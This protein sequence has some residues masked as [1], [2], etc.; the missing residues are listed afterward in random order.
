MG[1]AVKKTPLPAE[2]ISASS[3]SAAIEITDYSFCYAGASTPVLRDCTFRLNY[4]EL[5][6]LSG[7]SGAGKSTLLASIIGS[8]P[9]LMRGECAGRILING[10]NMEKDASDGVANAAALDGG[11]AGQR[12]AHD[13]ADSWRICERAHLVG[14]VLQDADSQI[15][16]AKVED[17]VAFGCEN[18]GMD[19]AQ[20]GQNVDSSCRLMGLERAWG[21]TTLSGG[22]KQRLVTAATL[23]MGQRILVFD[24]PLANLDR[25]GATLLLD[26][27][28]EMVREGYAVLIIEHR[29]DHV[30][31]YADRLVW[32]QD[33]R[34]EEKDPS[35]VLGRGSV[36]ASG[37]GDAGGASGAVTADSASDAKDAPVLE[38]RHIAYGV[39]GRAILEDI[40]LS[41][42]RG[43]R[44][45]L[46]GENGCGKTTLLRIIARLL[47][48][49]G[50]VILCDGAALSS[51]HPNA[52]WFKRVG[53]VFQNPG[54]QLFMPQVRAEVEYRR[55]D[56]G[57]ARECLERFG[58]AGLEE[59]HPHSLSEG[60]KRALSIAVI[61][62]QEP[63]VLLLDE[64]TVG[65]DFAALKRMVATLNEMCA[66]RK[67]SIVT[68][69]HDQRCA[70][71]LADRL[72]WIA[73]GR[74]HPHHTR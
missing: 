50:G 41:I 3:Q 55:A 67:M 4:G 28:K 57:R 63:E 25:A 1:A 26:T 11:D 36:S 51:T 30:L 21:T 31:P 69:T 9:H 29:L 19:V 73:D 16:H 60:Q 15:V 72:L 66:Q 20:I 32:L 58:L 5:V 23:A 22:Q 2:G 10:V 47:R 71:A 56:A 68:V 14:S 7:D 62:A 40:D 61:V 13:T 74:I 46:L 18:L 33:G 64:P 27:L 53:Y 44:I 24:E 34:C 39:K 59:R 48:P 38:L 52:S 8:I 49:S 42:G 54:Y 65:Q 45:V 17:E 35:S 6:V 37:A 43:E 12:G 70:S